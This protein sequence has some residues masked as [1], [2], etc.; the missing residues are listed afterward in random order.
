MRYVRAPTLMRYIGNLSTESKRL[1]SRVS[2]HSGFYRV[3]QR[4]Q[5]IVLSSNGKSINE[6]IDIFQVKRA[7]VYNWFNAFEQSWF[8]GLYDNKA[9]GRK[10][11]FTPQQ[12]MQIKGICTLT[13]ERLFRGG[14]SLGRLPKEWW[15]QIAE[16]LV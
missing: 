11:T 16:Q 6:L 4:V 12:Q 13:Y 10:P 14:F 5:C 8:A 7:T 3:S 15:H 1:L 2:K 9:K